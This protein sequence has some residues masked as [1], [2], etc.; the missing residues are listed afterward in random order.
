MLEYI[1]KSGACMAVFLLFYKI[2]L[3]KESMHNFKRFYLLW[4]LIASFIIPSIVFVDYIVPIAVPKVK[5]P[6]SHDLVQTIPSESPT[7]MDSINWS[8]I[9]WTLYSI[10]FIGFGIRFLKHLFQIL[11]RI[12]TNPKLK[13]D[14]SIK[15]LLKQNLPPHTF[16]SYIFLNKNKFEASAIPKEVL[17]HEETHAKQKHSLDVVFIELLQ[18]LLWFNPLIHLFRKSIKLNHEFLADSAVLSKEENTLN[19][20]NTVLSYLSKDGFNTHQSTGI[21]N[22]INYSSIK[23]RFKVM[24]K[25]TSTTGIVLRTFLVLPLFAL[26]L[27]GFSEHKT[28][29]METT[30]M[31]QTVEDVNESIDL[32]KIYIDE[33]QQI[34]INEDMVPVQLLSERITQLMKTSKGEGS[35][36]QGVQVINTGNL[37][38]DL[39]NKVKREIEKAGAFIKFVVT[40][41]I[42]IFDEEKWEDDYGEV[43]IIAKDTLAIRMKDGKTI[44][45]VSIKEA[46]KKATSEEIFEYNTLAKKYNTMLAKKGNIRILKS[47]VDRMEYLYGLMSDKQKATA[48]IFPDFP[49]PPPAPEAPKAHNEREE[50]S[51]K[52]KE[53]I[54]EQDPYDVVG[55]GIKINRTRPVSPKFLKGEVSDIRPP[56]PRVVKGQVSDIPPPPPPEPQ[57][58]LD[59]VIE[60][61][62]KGA[63]F[64]YEGKEISSEKAIDLMK[65]NKGINIDSQRKNGVQQVNLSNEPITIK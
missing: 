9:L 36:K 38:I 5:V 53:I 58:P 10:G 7:E 64:Y 26:L 19:Y 24:R 30:T 15:V 52:I 14:H 50:A 60:M 12:K 46:Q 21:T 6:L 57:S 61:A 18:V 17:L 4:V 13:Q 39:F 43:E 44:K 16:F 31:I 23:K 1:L 27:Y 55:A 35:S 42:K 37:N 40:D 11:H 49:Q 65:K 41:T 48:E 59:H 32:I 22:A 63:I 8:L 34:T 62:K 29:E 20:Q 56:A 25:K 28:I 2:L 47:E 33:K 45:G 3:E 54:E 51:N